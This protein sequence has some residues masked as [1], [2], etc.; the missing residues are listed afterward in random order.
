MPIERKRLNNRRTKAGNALKKKEAKKRMFVT[1]V[2]NRS[3][4]VRRFREIYYNITTELG[5]VDRIT[6]SQR[7]LARR[8][9]NLAMYAELIEGQLYCRLTGEESQLPKDIGIHWDV[10]TY[11]SISKTIN[12]LCK[13]LG[14]ERQA[15][16]VTPG[17]KDRQDTKN[18]DLDD[19]AKSR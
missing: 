13:T 17:E 4:P 7:Q 12:T 18:M 11:E 16:N 9:A 10:D 2:D 15:I 5:G 3:V 1:P 6:E 8:V 14:I 19:Y